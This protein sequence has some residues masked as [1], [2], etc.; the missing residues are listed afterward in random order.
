MMVLQPQTNLV[1]EKQKRRKLAFYV[2]EKSTGF[3]SIHRQPCA[4]PWARCFGPLNKNDDKAEN[5]WFCIMCNLVWKTGKMF[6]IKD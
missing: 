2:L 3:S 6:R 4:H 1:T 5:D